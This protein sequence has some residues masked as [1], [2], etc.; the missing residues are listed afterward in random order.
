M[1]KK[2]IIFD[3][4]EKANKKKS[5]KLGKGISSK[6]VAGIVAAVLVVAI[7]VGAVVAVVNNKNSYIAEVN[8]V[9]ISVA[10]FDAELKAIEQSYLQEA[11]ADGKIEDPDDT[12]EVEKFWQ[13]KNEDGVSMRLAAKQEALKNVVEYAVQLLVAEEKG[14]VLTQQDKS[15]LIKSAEANAAN[16]AMY[17][18]QS[19]G[20][21]LDAKQFVEQYYGTKYDEYKRMY[22]ESYILNQLTVMMKAQMTVTDDEIKAWYDKAPETYD[23]YMV[24]SIYVSYQ[25]TNDAKKTVMLEGDELTKK[26][27]TVEKLSTDLT[28]ENFKEYAKD[29]SEVS[30]AT[31]PLQLVDGKLSMSN[32]AVNMEEV[33]KWLNETGMKDATQWTKIEVK[34]TA[35]EF[36][37]K[38]VGVYFVKFDKKVDIHTEDNTDAAEMRKGIK[39]EILADNYQKMVEEWAKESKYEVTFNGDIYKNYN[40]AGFKA[41]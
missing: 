4:Y 38:V 8:G 18:N 5:A 41:E 36:K 30:V 37:D 29:N 11:E 32:S 16:N 3:D 31:S 1:G 26:Q 9:K 25:K 27:S 7:A 12:T 20:T 21:N 22:L 13:S 35:S 15:N 40:V 6:M 14:I 33:N 2:T 19:Y 23:L 28:A 39:Q 34:G 24:D 10:D 17:Y